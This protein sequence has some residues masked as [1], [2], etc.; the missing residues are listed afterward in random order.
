VS[1]PQNGFLRTL[2]VG[3]IAGLSYS[4]VVRA[5]GGWDDVTELSALYL[6]A[7][8]AT[9]AIVVGRARSTRLAAAVLVAGVGAASSQLFDSLLPTAIVLTLVLSYARERILFRGRFE[10]PLQIELAV[11]ALSVIA[12]ETIVDRSL[13]GIGT[14][15][16]TYWLVQSAFFLVPSRHGDGATPQEDPFEA[17]V[18]RATDLMDN[19][20]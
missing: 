18:G 16:W 7:A 8:V 13:D 4:P 9:Y 20:R 19:T 15:I 17:A 1:A 2:V 10:H 6:T 5:L 14:S 11:G 3:A 12:A